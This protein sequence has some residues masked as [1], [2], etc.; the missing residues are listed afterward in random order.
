MFGVWVVSSIV[1]AVGLA[2]TIIPGLPGMPLVLAGIALFAFGTSFEVI[3]PIQLALMVLL[4]L[5]GMGLNLLGN[6]MGARKFGASRLG[7][8]GALLGLIPGLLLAGPFGLILG[9][10][11]G[12][13]LF[14]LLAGRELQSALRSGA[15]VVV[16]Y[17]FGALAEVVIA[18]ILAGWFLLSTFGAVTRI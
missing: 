5:A 6:L 1:I 11:I 17:L 12:A 8:L 13:I 15:G 16:G 10:L 4:G 18:L 14:E 2:G 9:P 7:L 3:G